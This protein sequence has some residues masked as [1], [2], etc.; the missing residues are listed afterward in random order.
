MNG[1]TVRVYSKAKDGNTQLTKNFQVKEF[2]CSDGTDTIFISSLLVSVLQN[3]RDHYGKAV[4]INS[5]YRTEAHNKKIGGAAYSQH[6]Y[7]I[8]ADIHV[9]GVK[10]KE[11][12]AY[13]ETLLPTSGGIGIYSSFVHVDVRRTRARWNG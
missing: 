6:K 2:A 12:A 13:I 4:H 3:V 5:A 1:Q 7:G 9:D 10:P 11:L 8:A